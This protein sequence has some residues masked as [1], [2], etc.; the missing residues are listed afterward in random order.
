MGGYTERDGPAAWSSHMKHLRLSAILATTMCVAPFAQEAK[1]VPKD[2]VRVMIPGCSKGYVFTAGRAAEDQP[3]GSAVAAGTHLR[4]SA[5]K[6]IMAELKGQEG[7]RV[8]ITGLIKR[9][10][11]GQEGIAVGRG[12]RILPGNPGPAAGIGGAMSAAGAAQPMIDVEGWRHLPGD[13]PR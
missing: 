11:V 9:G 3:G 12:V 8:E 6:R 1:R 5:P 13:C 10:Q 2:S 4:M 7:S